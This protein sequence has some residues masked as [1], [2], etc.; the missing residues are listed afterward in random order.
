MAD[1]KVTI[2]VDANDDDIKSLIKKLQEAA[3]EGE[4]FG[5]SL[6]N[7]MDKAGAAA[8]KLAGLI[9]TVGLAVAAFSIK[10]AGTA[11][12]V[13][14]QFTQTFGA[15][16]KEA[17]ASVESMADEFGMVPSRL[18]AP[19]AMMTSMFKGLGY[20][21]K[22]AMKMA[23]DATRLTADAAA[24]FDTSYEDAN[25]A[26]SSFIK[27]NYEGG[28]A[29]GL[30]ANETQ[31]AAFAA[32]KLG[33]DWK[34][35]DEAGKQFVRLNYAQAMQKAAGATGQA[36]READGLENVLGNVKQGVTDLAAAF[37]A[38]LLDPFIAAA[39]KAVSAMSGLAT[40]FTKFPGE[41]YTVIAA[42]SAL[43]AVLLTAWATTVKW[44]AV[45]VALK[46]TMLLFASPIVLIVAAIGALVV[47]F[48]HF[49]NT[50]ETFR[51]AVN[52]IVS[53]IKGF[54]TSLTQSETWIA[55]VN[56]L[57]AAFAAT[58]SAL[59]TAFSA[60]AGFAAQLWKAL[61]PLASGALSVIVELF[62]KLSSALLTIWEAIQP[63]ISGALSAIAGLF[64]SLGG[65][66]GMAGGIMTVLS[67]VL[68]T[69]GIALLGISGPLG[70]V[71]SLIA[72]FG[73]A[74]LKTGDLSAAGVTKVFDNLSNM[75][76]NVTNMLA[77]A[78]PKFVKI[79]T[80][81]LLKLIEGLTKA[82]PGIVATIS[83]IIETITTTLTTVLPVIIEAGVGILTALIEGIVTALPLLIEAYIS[84]ITSLIDTIIQFL[85]MIIEAGIQILTAL[86]G[87]I[88]QF[89]P[90][91]I[92]AGIQI[93]MALIQGIIL[94]LPT[95]I[96]VGIQL[97]MALI[98]VVIS[99]LPTIIEAG[100]QILMA[101]IQGII[102]ML[103][104][105]VEAALLLITS[106]FQALIESLPLIIE[107]G[108]E[109]LFAL[110]DGLIQI[111]PQLIEAAI[112]IVMALFQALIDNLPAI[113]EAGIK[114]LLGLIDG[115][116]QMLP[117]LID[118]ALTLVTSLVDGLID[119][120][121]VIIEAGWDLLKAIVKGLWDNK[122]EIAEAGKDLVGKLID[123]VVGM[124][125]DLVQAGK[126]L[127][128]GLV[129]GIKSKA[130]D[131][132]DAVKNV[133]NDV[134]E[135]AKGL[136]K[137]HSPSRVFRDEVGKYI[138]AGIAVGIQADSNKID[139]AMKKML[140]IPKY[141]AEN[142]IGLTNGNN[143][144]TN[145]ITSNFSDARTVS[146][147]GSLSN[148]LDRLIAKNTNLNVNLD[149]TK[150]ANNANDK[151]GSQTELDLYGQ[152]LI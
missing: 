69:I 112:T 63:L 141:T 37:G 110:I 135:G 35:L 51:N 126:D 57:S 133:A 99:L 148:Q 26:L 152:G 87:A 98:N 84:I 80:D 66:M 68:V 108:I 48:M 116:I 12:A 75:I 90:I 85:P 43:V 39:K 147:L 38:P 122:D 34:T 128:G 52:A 113:I 130:K 151:L 107:A 114:L 103:P 95:L 25:A 97:I 94:I 44:Q 55:V 109:L 132:V 145:S 4:D 2:V 11:K 100:I 29:I 17:T 22:T 82:I 104:V 138:P 81:I 53:A 131:A 121:D 118:A 134:V 7:S 19:F 49:Y 65:S 146:A 61:E 76:T 5:D 115:L 96:E 74:W 144:V 106:L 83:T 111:L 21:T 140:A 67:K 1:G 102:Q 8:G 139:S 40:Y 127:I 14:S 92:E 24:F 27:G 41:V 79:G 15:L 117:E 20:D 47:A 136:L 72:S 123:A 16:K 143:S 54:I 150:L 46:A 78:I 60:V 137:I 93:I 30:F 59:G 124:G 88:V 77:K 70:M 33:K 3:D 56:A 58:M 31:M 86:I 42:V 9:G 10:A 32:D 45:F 105:L 91:I 119:N 50:S 149:G 142:S 36:A 28:E 125:E 13:E 62:G 23:E 120:I 6:E 64:E 18:K 73:I 71:V 89:L 101:L 129:E